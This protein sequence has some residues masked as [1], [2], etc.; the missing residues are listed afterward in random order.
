MVAE[1]ALVSVTKLFASIAAHL[2]WSVGLLIRQKQLYQRKQPYTEIGIRRLKCMRCGNQA[3]QQWQ[4]CADD[5]IY[6]PI[7]ADCDIELNILVLRWM[8]DSQL[9]SKIKKYK[10]RLRC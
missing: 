10:A 3:T 9:D 6:R 5:N 8:G 1:N 7:C 4:V 2:S